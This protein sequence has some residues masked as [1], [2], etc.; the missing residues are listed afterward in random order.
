[1]WNSEAGLIRPIRSSDRLWIAAAVEHHF[2]SDQAV[3]RGVVHN[4]GELPGLVALW[5]ATPAGVLLYEIRDLECE[6]VVL[7]SL[8]K[9]QGIATG[10]LAAV[11]GLARES[12][13]KRLWLVTTNDNRPA[14]DLYRKRGWR[15]CAIHRNAV[16]ESRHLKPEIPAFGY[17]G[18]PIRDELEFELLLADAGP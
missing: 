9:R 8:R 14:I 4:T 5:E 1:M 3:S 17:G 18:T 13:L 6:V 2:G 16:M 15:L 12:G 10:L 7:I 11:Q